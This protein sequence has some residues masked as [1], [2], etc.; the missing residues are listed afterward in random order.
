MGVITETEHSRPGI[1]VLSAM[2]G[3]IHI[4]LYSD[5]YLVYNK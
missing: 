5:V 2:G 3:G 4:Y 1:T